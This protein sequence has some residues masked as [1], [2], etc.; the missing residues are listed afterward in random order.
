[1]DVVGIAELI[2]TIEF[3]V[4]VVDIDGL[5]ES[6]DAWVLGVGGVEGAEFGGFGYCLGQGVFA[7]AASDEED[8]EMVCCRIELGGHVGIVGVLDWVWA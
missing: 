5:G 7:C 8:I 1:M 3:F 6:G 2:E 4:G